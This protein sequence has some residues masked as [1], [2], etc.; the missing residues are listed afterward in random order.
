[1]N[2]SKLHWASKTNQIDADKRRIELIGLQLTLFDCA[3]L[4]QFIHNAIMN[5]Q[6][7]TIL[8]G[9]IHAYNLAYENPW[10][11]DYFNQADA[12]RLDGAGISLGVRMLGLNPP[13]RMTW[14]DFAWDLADMA[15]EY[16][17]SLALLGGR[18]GIAEKA[19]QKLQAQLSTLRIAGCHDGYF[20]KGVGSIENEQLLDW[21]NHISPDI[22]VVGFGMPLQEEWLMHNRTKLTAPVVLTGGAVFDYLSGETQRAPR[23]MTRNGLEWLGRLF[24]EPRR[25]WQRYLI[26]NPKFMFRLSR[27]LLVTRWN[28]LISNA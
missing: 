22:I 12:I 11:R 18:P 25:L 14:A 21:L 17:H 24:I 2:P 5:K 28:R 8:S 1:M 10:L 7:V 3:E 13:P 6:C 20:D 9:N 19:A 4:L 27:Q 16:D 15:Q 26:G 23:W